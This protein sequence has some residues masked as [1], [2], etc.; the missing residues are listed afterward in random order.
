VLELIANEADQIRFFMKVIG[1]SRLCRYNVVNGVLCYHGNILQADENNSGQIDFPEFLDIVHMLGDHYRLHREEVNDNIA[2]VKTAIEIAK[3]ER[4]HYVQVL[5]EMGVRT[6]EYDNLRH[7]AKQ[8]VGH[9]GMVK[10]II[11]RKESAPVS[12]FDDNGGEADDCKE[13]S[14]ALHHESTYDRE[15]PRVKVGMSNVSMLS[16]ASGMDDM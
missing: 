4:R 5:A 1:M 8:T 6:K 14:V 3:R 2:R 12:R 13:G 10:R 9:G 7:S 16:A 11:D 15:S